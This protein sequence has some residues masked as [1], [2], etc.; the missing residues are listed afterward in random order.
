M[1]KTVEDAK[2]IMA[3]F[4]LVPTVKGN[5]EAVISQEPAPGTHVH[6]NSYVTITLGTPESISGEVTVPGVLG[7]S[8]QEVNTLI[9]DAGLNLELA[10]NTTGKNIIALSQQPAEG[11]KVA[12]GTT[13]KVTFGAQ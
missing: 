8:A 7:K 12:G 5:G 2:R 4:N 10:G 13:V 9:T 1:N 3:S 11:T 6:N